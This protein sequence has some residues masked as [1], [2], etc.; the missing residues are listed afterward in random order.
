MITIYIYWNLL[1]AVVW[2]EIERL[3][4]RMNVSIVPGKT[5]INEQI[6][7]EL[8]LYFEKKLDAFQTPY[9]CLGSDFQKSVWQALTEIDRGKTSSYKE[10]AAAIGNPKGMRAV[11]N[12]NGANQLAIIIPCHRVIQIDGSLGGYGGGVERK[13][14]LLKHER[15]YD[16]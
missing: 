3:R 16:L 1:T 4:N 5:R 14:W 7:E 12:A 8:N 2:R 13:K 6:K 10:L 11:G 15:E 9:L